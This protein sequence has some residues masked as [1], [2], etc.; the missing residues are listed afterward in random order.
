MALPGSEL[1]PC[2][3]TIRAENDVEKLTVDWPQSFLAV[4]AK[5]PLID[6]PDLYWETQPAVAGVQPAR[7]FHR[8]SF[9][10]CFKGAMS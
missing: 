3:V 6:K 2:F 7:S 8:Q 4:I 9:P 1:R 5:V 10:P